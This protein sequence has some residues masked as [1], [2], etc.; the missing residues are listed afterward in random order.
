MQIIPFKEASSFIEQITLSGTIFVLRF[1][2]NSLNEFWS[3]D[4]QNRDEEPIIMGIKIVPNYPLLAQY[5]DNN[6]PS[7]EIVCQNIV[8]SPDGI[9]RFDIGQKFLLVYYEEGELETE[10][11]A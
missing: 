1:N 11:G 4:I 10:L 3:M 8:R 9:G 5:T 7:G 6:L 2:W